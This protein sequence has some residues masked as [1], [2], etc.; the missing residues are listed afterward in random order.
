MSIYAKIKHEG[1]HA[2][3]LK[4]NMDNPREV[5][6]AE[7]WQHEQDFGRV[8]SHLLGSG[9][10]GGEVTPSE[11]DI[12]VA[13]T[14]IQWLGSAVGQSFL[15]QVTKRCPEICDWICRKKNT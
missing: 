2:Y 14:V 12:E 11:R 4:P 15:E 5:A 1:L 9:D 13:A 10:I 3:R 8:L 7:Q 6:F